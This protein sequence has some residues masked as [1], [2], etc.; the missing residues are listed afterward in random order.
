MADY[1][2]CRK[3]DGALN[4][5]IFMSTVQAYITSELNEEELRRMLRQRH[6]ESAMRLVKQD[7]ERIQRAKSSGTSQW[8]VRFEGD[9]FHTQHSTESPWRNEDNPEPTSDAAP[10]L[11][12]MYFLVSG[13]TPLGDVS[14]PSTPTVIRRLL[15][16]APGLWDKFAAWA[17]LSCFGEVF[18]EGPLH[19]V[20]I[21]PPA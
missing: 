13:D 10:D 4:F 16:T 14:G 7:D 1:I 18:Q 21:L 19:I 20:R 11:T 5:R 9:R 6:M 17:E 15:K 12:D 2:D 3:K 8:P